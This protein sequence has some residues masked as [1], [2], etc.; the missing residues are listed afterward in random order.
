M[1]HMFSELIS[2]PK[3]MYILKETVINSIEDR[4][5]DMGLENYSRLTKD[6]NKN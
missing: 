4:E 2:L 5:I 3:K 1:K 6:L